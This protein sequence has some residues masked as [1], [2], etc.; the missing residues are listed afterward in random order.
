LGIVLLCIY[1]PHCNIEKE[2]NIWNNLNDDIL[3]KLIEYITHFMKIRYKKYINQNL[4]DGF[5]NLSTLKEKYIRYLGYFSFV[6]LKRG[7]TEH[8]KDYDSYYIKSLVNKDNYIKD[9][10]T[11]YCNIDNIL[12][13]FDFTEMRE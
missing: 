3:I 11:R 12:K 10:D 4:L 13:P 2:C 7:I 6:M 9:S 8:I 5:K 1:V